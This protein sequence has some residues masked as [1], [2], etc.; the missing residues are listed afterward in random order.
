[1]SIFGSARFESIPRQVS[2]ASSGRSEKISQISVV[3]GKAVALSRYHGSR[4]PTPDYGLVRRRSLNSGGV[5]IAGCQNDWPRATF[6]DRARSMP[7]LRKVLASPRSQQR[8][9]FQFPGALKSQPSI[10]VIRNPLNGPVR[11]KATSPSTTRRAPVISRLGWLEPAFGGSLTHSYD[12]LACRAV[13]FGLP[14]TEGRS[15]PVRVDGSRLQYVQ[16]IL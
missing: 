2:R 4:V 6:T 9:A 13:R 5:C 8:H 14:S 15:R 7:S 3:W 11:S 16:S 10:I 12:T 1:M